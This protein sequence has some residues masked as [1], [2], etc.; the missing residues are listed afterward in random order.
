MPP[1]APFRDTARTECDAPV[2]VARP[3]FACFQQALRPRPASTLNIYNW[4]DYIDPALLDEF[5]R[6]YGIK[7]NYDVYDSSEMVDT[8]LMTGHTGYDV[9]FHSSSFSARLIP[10][11]RVPNRG[12]RAPAQLASH[13]P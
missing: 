12:Y 6:E 13:R 10:D 5:E 1:R 3:V 8:K 9:V 7:V 2:A 11:R 4:A